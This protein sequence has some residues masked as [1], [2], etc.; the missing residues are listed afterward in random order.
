M[1]SSLSRADAT[2]HLKIIAV[3]LLAS[4]AVIWI[5]VFA[6]VFAGS[7]PVTTGHSAVAMAV[8]SRL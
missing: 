6:H 3:A 1:N 8:V 2:T 7:V 4:V 5:G